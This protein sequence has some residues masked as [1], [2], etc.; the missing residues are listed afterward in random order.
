MILARLCEFMTLS[1]LYILFVVSLVGY[2]A[3]V[4]FYD[5]ASVEHLEELAHSADSLK[6][7][8][9]NQALRDSFSDGDGKVTNF[10]YFKLSAMAYRLESEMKKEQ[11]ETTLNKIVDTE[12]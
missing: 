10:E 9:F 1:R 12:K 11:A 5:E 2:G 8:A 6:N 3:A 4:L 7:P